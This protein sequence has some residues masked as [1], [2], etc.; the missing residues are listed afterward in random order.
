MLKPARNIML[1]LALTCF[2]SMATGLTLFVHIISLD[3]HE[4]HDHSKCPICQQ[5]LLLSK[6]AV[7]E[8]ETIIE[9]IELFSHNV[10]F[11]TQ[12]EKTTIKFLF[13]LLRAPPC[14]LFFNF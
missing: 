1:I 12:E 8:P 2:I 10:Q 6:K 3:Q 9:K 11:Y 13:P 4:H 7:I 14:A 5:S